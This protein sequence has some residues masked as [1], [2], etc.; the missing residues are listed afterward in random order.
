MT[1]ILGVA[2]GT[3]VACAAITVCACGGNANAGMGAM[4]PISVHLVTQT[5]T[6]V[7]GGPAVSVVITIDSPSETAVV[8]VGGLPAG[9]SVSYAASDTNPSG[10]LTLTAN[11]TAIK[12]TFMPTVT[13]LSAGQTAMTTFTLNVVAMA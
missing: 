5:V 1:R 8:Q 3:L 13:V 9:V 11:A 4:N 7:Q 2:R 12:G 6:V 10:L